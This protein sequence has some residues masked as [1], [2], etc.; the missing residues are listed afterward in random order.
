MGYWKDKSPG[1][2]YRG[3]FMVSTRESLNVANVR[4]VLSGENHRA[5]LELR[6]SSV[7]KETSLCYMYE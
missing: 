2:P 4:R 6:I 1:R 3:K 7:V 5:E